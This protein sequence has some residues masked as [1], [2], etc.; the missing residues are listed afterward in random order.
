MRE[1]IVKTVLSNHADVI[2]G[3]SRQEILIVM[4]ILI[5]II[6]ADDLTKTGIKPQKYTS[7]PKK[8]EKNDI[9]LCIRATIVN[10]QYSDGVYCLGQGVAAIRTNNEVLNSEYLIW[11]LQSKVST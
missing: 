5:A 7:A 6:R 2:M 11:E 1:D 4:I 3:Q 8:T 9:L 10:I